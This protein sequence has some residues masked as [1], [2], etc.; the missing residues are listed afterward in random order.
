MMKGLLVAGTQS[1]IGKTTITLAILKALKESGYSVQSFKVGPDF[2]DPSHLEKVTDA[3]CY[4]LDSFM[5][6]EEG[7]KRELAKA[8]ADYAVIEGAM[9][10]Y[11]GISSSA[12]IADL[13]KIPILLVV[14][15]STSSESVAAQALGFIKYASFTPFKLTIAGVIANRV[16]SE[17]H[18]ESIRR[19]LN[20]IRIP[21]IGAI[22]RDASGIPSRHLGL[23]MGAET[24]LTSSA[25]KSVYDSLDIEFIE[26]SAAELTPDR[27]PEPKRTRHSVIGIAM[28]AAFCFY[29]RSNI[30][31]LQKRARVVY[32]SP[33]RDA[34][35]DVDGLYFGGGYPELHATQLSANRHLL[36][37]VGTAADDGMPIYGEC[38]GLMYLSRSLSTVENESVSLTNILPVDVQMTR[39]RQ[40]LGHAEVEA[41]RDCA[42]ARCGDTLRGHEYHYST[43]SVDRDARFAYRV[44]KGDGINGC[45]GIMQGNV[46]ASYLHTHVYSM[47]DEFDLFVAKA[48]AFS[49]A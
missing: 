34:L 1:G 41:V 21:L 18:A 24:S 4:N 12:E 11:D 42:I 26:R 22:E 28:D 14:D 35:P 25:L 29:Y 48:K 46:V 20:A 43:A 16:G 45:D 38:G 19:S 37:Q 8:D 33:I 27:P 3:P 30:E 31:S 40:A 13:L 32:F 39:K 6:G 5:M 9:G 15:A 2:I 49:R 47:P 7:V 17:K 36:E 23:Y 10:L 44:T